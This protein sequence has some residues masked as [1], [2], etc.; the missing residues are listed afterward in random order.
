MVLILRCANEFGIIL[1][2]I[3]SGTNENEKEP[4]C[5]IYLHV[6]ILHSLDNSRTAKQESPVHESGAEC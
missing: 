1:L 6:N 3:I 5:G 4:Y 2:E